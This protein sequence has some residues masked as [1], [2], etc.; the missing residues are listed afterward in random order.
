[1]T[2]LKRC[3]WVP[4]T[5]YE[6]EE[7]NC[8]TVLKIIDEAREGSTRYPSYQPPTISMFLLYKTRCYAARYGP[9]I[10]YSLLVIL[11]RMS[12]SALVRFKLKV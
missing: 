10:S 9:N 2:F 3:V 12:S 6:R 1:M 7:E 4:Y 8:T 11:S 5:L